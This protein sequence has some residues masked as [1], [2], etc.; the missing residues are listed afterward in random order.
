MRW[1][2]EPARHTDRNAIQRAHFLA[3]RAKR[4]MRLEPVDAHFR[5]PSVDP[6]LKPEELESAAAFGAL[7]PE[8]RHIAADPAVAGLAVLKPMDI[9][10]GREIHMRALAQFGLRWIS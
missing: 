5:A 1:P 2:P 7:D 6:R 10:L 8:I 4:Q 3:L 9:D